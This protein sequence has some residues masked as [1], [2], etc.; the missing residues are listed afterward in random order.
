MCFLGGPRDIGVF[1]CQSETVVHMSER[2]LWK[3]KVSQI[4]APELTISTRNGPVF[5]IEKVSLPNRGSFRAR[6][7]LR[8]DRP[9]VRFWITSVWSTSHARR[10]KAIFLNLS[11]PMKRYQDATKHRSSSANPVCHSRQRR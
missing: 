3:Q 11:H 7:R 9:E 4:S 2:L 6:S 1:S 10:T 8:G 5:R